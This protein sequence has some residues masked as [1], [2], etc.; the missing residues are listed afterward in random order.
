MPTTDDYGQGVSI[1]SLTDAPDMSRAARD[2]AG[3]IVPRSVMR[4]ADAAE[5]NATLTSPVAGM[6]AWL[7]AEKLVTIYDGTAWVVMAAGT[8]A[9]TTPTLV[10]GFA[11]DGNSNGNFGW[12]LVNLFGEPTVMLRGAVSVTYSPAIPNS[13]VLMTAPLPTSARPT[14]LRTVTIPCSDVGSTRITLKLDAKP[15]GHLEIYGTNSSDNRPIWIGFNGV[16]YP[17]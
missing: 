4:F 13:G 14:S 12:R 15:D 3:G 8:S 11:H 16:Y 7:T 9:W 10:S 1:A 17:L 5:R 6:V 2:L